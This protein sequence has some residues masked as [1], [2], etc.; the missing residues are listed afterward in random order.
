MRGRTHRL[1]VL[2]LVLAGLGLMGSCG[3]DTPTGPQ[4][5]DL[6]FSPESIILPGEDR[7]A[8]LVLRNVGTRDL[9]PVDIGRNDQVVRI[10]PPDSLC[11][12]ITVNLAPTQVSSL[13]AGAEVTVDITLDLSGPNITP[14]TCPA[15]KYNAS[16]L[17]AVNS[18]V[19]GVAAITFDWDGTP[20]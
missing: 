1:A 15:G 8:V 4:F 2:A 13:A 18:Q 12:V 17:A 3:G 14:I 9:G 7:T 16:I 10:V 6:A 19:L 5:G 20:P 11:N